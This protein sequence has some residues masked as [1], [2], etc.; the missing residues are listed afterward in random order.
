[1]PMQGF[2]EQAFFHRIGP[3]LLIFIQSAAD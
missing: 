1:M 2:P 3:A